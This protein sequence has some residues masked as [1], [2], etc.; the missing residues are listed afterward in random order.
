MFQGVEFFTN[1]GDFINNY[2]NNVKDKEL[3]Q[4]WEKFCFIS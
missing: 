4:I 1:K 2:R 3:L